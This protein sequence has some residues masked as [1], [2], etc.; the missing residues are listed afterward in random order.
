MGLRFPVK[1]MTVQELT[2]RTS[3]AAVPGGNTESY[4]TVFYDTQT[5]LAAG[6]NQLT[7]FQ[8]TNADATLSNMEAAGS[9]PDP[10]FWQLWGVTLTPLLPV[11]D[12][13][14]PTAWRDME[15]LVLTGRPI[16]TLTISDKN[17]G[18]IPITFVHASGGVTGFGYQV[19]AV[20]ATAIQYANNG[21]FDGGYC[22]A[23]AI[24]IPPKVNFNWTI[25]WGNPQ[26][27]A[28]DTLLRL[29]MNGVIH[30]RIL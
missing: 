25:R 28:A 20:A 6:S 22:Y 7:F 9:F 4:P 2:Q 29:E 21:T 13:A 24:L 11:S 14:V 12:A 23:G 3:P 1:N 16:L 27:V 15:R 30:R 10:K 17:Y 26:A 5:Y 19:A 18:P 8:N